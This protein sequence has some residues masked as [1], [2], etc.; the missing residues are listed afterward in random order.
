MKGLEQR[1]TYAAKPT[2]WS[3]KKISGELEKSEADKE[4]IVLAADLLREYLQGNKVTS[5]STIP[6][7]RVHLFPEKQHPNRGSAGDHNLK[8]GRIRI[9]KKRDSLSLMLTLV[10]EMAHENGIRKWSFQVATEG[11]DD[12][13]R[14]GYRVSDSRGASNDDTHFEAFDE[15]VVEMIAL[16][17][18]LQGRERVAARL[19]M[20][21]NAYDQKLSESG[22]YRHAVRVVTRITDGL[23]RYLKRDERAVW[24]TIV[25]GEVSGNMMWMRDIEE[26]FGEGSL[27]VLDRLVADPKNKDDQDL[28]EKVMTYFD[29]EDA[30]DRE[31]MQ[32]EIY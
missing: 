8:T 14:S 2:D 11:A 13:Y 15:G 29:L 17:A 5:G 1:I 7:E 3:E 23:A 32:A 22:F 16:G 6:V 30:R 31:R 4:M 21:L 26:V 20:P 10:H 28:N 19:D 12:L 25:Q 9:E 18:L 24:S 27:R